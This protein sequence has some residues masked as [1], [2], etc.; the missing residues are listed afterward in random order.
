MKVRTAFAFLL[1]AFFFGCMITYSAL[2]MST[3][4]CVRQ[5]RKSPIVNMH[6]SLVKRAFEKFSEDVITKNMF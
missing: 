6:I 5:V 3:Q 1:D 2:T 4:I